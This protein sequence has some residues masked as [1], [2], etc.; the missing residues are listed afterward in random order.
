[1]GSVFVKIVD[2]FHNLKEI[3]FFKIWL[4]AKKKEENKRTCCCL[5]SSLV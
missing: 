4:F 5:P 2:C 3:F 1:M